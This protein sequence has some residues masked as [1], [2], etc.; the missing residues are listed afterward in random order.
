MYVV[1]PLHKHILIWM[2]R[3]VG[4]GERT[5]GCGFVIKV[6]YIKYGHPF[7]PVSTPTRIFLKVETGLR[8]KDQ[9]VVLLYF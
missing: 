4:D 5:T 3:M 9:Y 7:C 6:L 2:L 8:G 1:L